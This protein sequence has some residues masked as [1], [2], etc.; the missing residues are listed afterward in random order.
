MEGANWTDHEV[1]QSNKVVVHILWEII[2]QVCTRFGDIQT[3]VDNNQDMAP[4][5]MD[6][7]REIFNDQERKK[8][9]QLEMAAVMDVGSHSICESNLQ[10]GG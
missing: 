10:L 5:T 9:L 8:H 2:D 4:K 7:I 3:F 1:F 6:H